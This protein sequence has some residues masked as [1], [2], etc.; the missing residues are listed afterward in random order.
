LPTG[1]A[2]FSGSPFKPTTGQ[3]YEVGMKYQPKNFNAF[4]TLALFH[5]TKQNVT[6]PDP[7]HDNF[8][9]QTGEIRSRGVE[10]EAAVSLA[11]GLNLKAA[12]TYNDVE[13]TKAN[14]DLDGLSAKGK[15]PKTTPDSMA[16]AW[17]D[18]TIQG[19]PLTG[20]GLGGGVRYVSPTFA[21]DNNT[22][23]NS[24]YTLFDA[25]L[26]YDLGRLTPVLKGARLAVNG[27]NLF[28]KEYTTCFTLFDCKWGARRTVI[29]T[30]AYRW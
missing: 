8:S 13:I 20:L 15:R 23:K 19:G 29:G 24:S 7:E 14:P 1:G 17:L 11:E 10:L 2:D 18:Y 26:R 16:S 12:Y 22:L 5:L 6:T 21:D 3:Q 30:L 25:A 4:F 9:V 27:N 28:N